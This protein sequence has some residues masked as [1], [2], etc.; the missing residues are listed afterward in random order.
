MSVSNFT[1]NRNGKKKMK[2][3]MPISCPANIAAVHAAA[4]VWQFPCG[5]HSAGGLPDPGLWQGKPGNS[6]GMV[7]H[8]GNSEMEF[9]SE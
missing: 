2:E 6:K 1:T 8:P 5:E 4:I 7:E 9:G 3:T